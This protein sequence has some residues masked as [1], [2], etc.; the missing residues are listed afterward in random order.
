MLIESNRH[1]TRIGVMEG[2]RLTEIFVEQHRH[3]GLVGNV[4][5]GRVTRVLPGMQAAFV[6]IGLERDAFLYVRDVR[7]PSAE[8]PA[9]SPSPSTPR[10]PSSRSDSTLDR[11]LDSDDLDPE[12]LESDDLDSGDPDSATLDS[13]RRMSNGW[14]RRDLAADD[15]PAID[16]LVKLGQELVVQVVKDPLPNKGAR[17]TTHV[18]LPGRYLVLLP[19]VRHFGVSRRIED[20]TERERL[21][22]LLAEIGSDEGG[23]I[24]RTVGEGEGLDEFRSDRDLLAHLWRQIR[25]R[26]QRVK[27]PTL[28]QTS[29]KVLR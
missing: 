16:D 2:D 11:S 7:D 17:I 3:R 12:D 28:L 13:G 24:V 20:E 10:R 6:D 18:T 27:A 21:L 29:S 4:Y 15:H 23:L 8:T 25:D 14:G 1:Q 9:P 22:D 26:S 5:K 19:T